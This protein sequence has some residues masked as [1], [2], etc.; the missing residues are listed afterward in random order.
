MVTVT[1]QQ[2]AQVTVNSALQTITLE[3]SSRPAELLLCN[4]WQGAKFILRAQAGGRVRVY[5]D[6]I[7]AESVYK[8]IIISRETTVADTLQLLAGC[9]GTKQLLDR[10]DRWMCSYRDLIL[11]SALQL[12]AESV[13]G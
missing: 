7:R 1:K 2:C 4:P 11:T 9:Y 13:R 3:D 12:Q 6:Q 5:D 10:P 8:S